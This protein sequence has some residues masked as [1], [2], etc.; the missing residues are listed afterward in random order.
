VANT[1]VQ[2][3]QP[4]ATNGTATADPASRVQ[5]GINQVNNQKQKVKSLKDQLNSIWKK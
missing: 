3:V 1:P 5:S 2:P 4:A